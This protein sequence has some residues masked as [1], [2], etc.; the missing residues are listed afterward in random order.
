MEFSLFSFFQNVI[1]RV[2]MTL[3]RVIL[4][5]EVKDVFPLKGAKSGKINL[6]L[7]W[8]PQPIFRDP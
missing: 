3:T 7:K 1:G 4:E 8:T 6:H 5:G 2:I